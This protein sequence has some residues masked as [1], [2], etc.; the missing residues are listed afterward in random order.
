MV[1]PPLSAGTARPTATG[2]ARPDST[3]PSRAGI[4]LSDRRLWAIS[5]AELADDVSRSRI[6]NGRNRTLVLNLHRVG[7]GVT[8]A[9]AAAS[10]GALAGGLQ[11]A[12]AGILSVVVLAVA[13]LGALAT[14]LAPEADTA[15]YR[16]KTNELEH[17]EGRIWDY[18]LFDLP[19]ATNLATVRERLACFREQKTNIGIT[20][21]SP[22]RP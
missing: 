11:G 17:L 12:A 6:R 3:K 5:F 16:S 21:A 9:A 14:A 22:T 18:L 19:G 1:A 2:P 8:A 7:T 10:A 13:T 4:D 15:R 20:A